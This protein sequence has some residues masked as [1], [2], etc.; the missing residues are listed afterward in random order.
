MTGGGLIARNHKRIISLAIKNRLAAIAGY[1]DFAMNSVAS[2]PTEQ[3]GS[4]RYRRAAVLVDK[5]L[6]GAKPFDLPCR[7]AKEI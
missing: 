2:C 5:I 1:E 3:T 7:A 4:N 6:K